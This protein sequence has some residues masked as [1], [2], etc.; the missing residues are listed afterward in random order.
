MDHEA[1]AAIREAING[2]YYVSDTKTAPGFTFCLDAVFF[3]EGG[4]ADNRAGLL[5]FYQKAL[6]AIG[7]PTYYLVDGR[8]RFK[9]V[10]RPDLNRLPEWA[11]SLEDGPDETRGAYGLCLETSEIG[12]GFTDRAYQTSNIEEH[13]GYSR[14]VLPAEYLVEHGA[15]GFIELVL[16]LAMNL[17][18]S[19]GSAGL[20]VNKAWNRQMRE[21][22]EA[23][24]ARFPGISL[25]DAD[26]FSKMVPRFSDY[27]EASIAG[28]NWLTFLDRGMV[29]RLARFGAAKGLRG[30]G[31]AQKTSSRMH[32]SRTET[33]CDDTGRARAF[34]R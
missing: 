12:G 25:A 11:A 9:K 6:S 22:V 15:G 34:E 30:Q 3:Y 18:F 33:R 19:S 2:D 31:V 16:D 13:S 1:I 24:A 4:F 10:R 29:K 7:T 21:H 5:D 27:Y 32:R 14:L 26:Y 8:G 23:T 17:N 20:S 28:I